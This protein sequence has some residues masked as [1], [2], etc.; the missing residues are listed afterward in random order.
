MDK[1]MRLMAIKGLIISMD[2][3]LFQRFQ[4]DGLTEDVKRVIVDKYYDAILEQLELSSDEKMK[5]FVISLHKRGIISEN[6]KNELL[7]KTCENTGGEVDACAFNIII[8]GRKHFVHTTEDKTIDWEKI[9]LL[10]ELAKT[11]KEIL[12]VKYTGGDT[13]NGGY[14]N[15]M[16]DVNE[17]IKIKECIIFYVCNTSKGEK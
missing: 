6:C 10:S 13:S 16:I 15:G 2:D 1:Y 12:I 8:N 17:S 5:E 9:V 14:S 4:K 11:G 3:Q 7:N